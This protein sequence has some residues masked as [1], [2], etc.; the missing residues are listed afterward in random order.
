MPFAGVLALRL[1]GV[2]PRLTSD[3]PVYILRPVIDKVSNHAPFICKL[4]GRSLASRRPRLENGVATR[5]I[6]PKAAVSEGDAYRCF[7][8][9]CDVFIATVDS[10]SAKLSVGAEGLA[11]EESI[12]AKVTVLWLAATVILLQN[13][14]VS[15]AICRIG[16]WRAPRGGV[17]RTLVLGSCR[18]ALL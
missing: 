1:L 17:R 7:P 8:G 3:L 16:R 2:R 12:E 4:P 6:A 11:A 15:A 9:K 10:E 18:C 5:D 13:N 14:P